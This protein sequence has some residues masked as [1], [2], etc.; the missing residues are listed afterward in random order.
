ME[1]P[2]SSA[3]SAPGLLPDSLKFLPQATSKDLWAWWSVQGQHQLIFS[4]DSPLATFCHSGKAP[5]WGVVNGHQ[6]HR[7]SL[8]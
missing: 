1:S 4:A 6:F 2:V 3:L 5:K 8:R 7:W